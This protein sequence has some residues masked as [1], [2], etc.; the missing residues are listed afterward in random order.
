MVGLREK[1]PRTVLYSLSGR[2]FFSSCDKETGN[3]DG[4][5]FSSFPR[6][7]WNLVVLWIFLEHVTLVMAMSG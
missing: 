1:G 7:T 2:R 5:H 6:V 3:G 4:C